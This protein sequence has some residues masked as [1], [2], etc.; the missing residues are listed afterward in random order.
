MLE[1]SVIPEADFISLDEFCK[2]PIYNKGQVILFNNDDDFLSFC[3]APVAVI[4]MDKDGNPYAFHG[5]Y[6]EIYQKCLAAGMKFGI[7]D[8]KSLINKRKVANTRVLVPDGFNQLRKDVNVQLPIQGIEDLCDWYYL[9]DGQVYTKSSIVAKFVYNLV[10][11]QGKTE[12][13]VRTIL[14]SFCQDVLSNEQFEELDQDG[15]DQYESFSIKRVKYHF[16][17]MSEKDLIIVA[18]QNGVRIENLVI[19]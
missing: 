15:K 16:G 7:R 2:T 3:V 18:A 1:L 19:K 9:C 13:D 8:E 14:Q 4:D 11:G 17:K 10:Y 12:A 5:Q 6:T